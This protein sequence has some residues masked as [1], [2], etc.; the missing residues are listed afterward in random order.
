M[1]IQINLYPLETMA[2]FPYL[3]RTVSFNNRD[4]AV[5]YVNLRKAQQ[6][7]GVGVKVLIKTRATV[8]AW[9]MIYKVVFQTVLICVGDSWVV[10]DVM[11]KVLEGFHHQVAHIIAEMSARQV[12]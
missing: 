7:W 10:M 6:W 5:L 12:G 11:F 1:S 8:Q 2:A 9:E 4:W 3:G